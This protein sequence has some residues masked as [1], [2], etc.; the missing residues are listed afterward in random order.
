MPHVSI[1]QTHTARTTVRDTQ[2]EEYITFLVKN[3]TVALSTADAERLMGTNVLTNSPITNIYNQALRLGLGKHFYPIRVPARLPIP[4]VIA[5][6]YLTFDMKQLQ[7]GYDALY[8]STAPQ[9][10]RDKIVTNMTQVTRGTEA[11]VQLDDARTFHTH[12]VRDLLS[13]S[14]WSADNTWLSPAIITLLARVYSIVLAADLAS[15][16]NIDHYTQRSLACIFAYYFLLRCTT[17]QGDAK[18]ILLGNL[19]RFLVEQSIAESIIAAI[20]EHV[21][22]KPENLALDKFLPIVRILD[23]PQ[24]KPDTKL[25]LG[26]FRSMAEDTQTSFLALEYPPYF[27]SIVLQ[28]ASGHHINFSHRAKNLNLKSDI[29]AI[30]DEMEKTQSFLGRI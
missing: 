20:D 16:Y 24:M 30:A 17:R 15:H 1:F 29:T 14:Y 25:L 22:G 6:R 27:A 28:V 18:A 7:S 23:Q 11:A 9:P 12:V 10:F 3:P 19:R 5:F 8:R 21:D 2:L 26:R 4:E 13:R